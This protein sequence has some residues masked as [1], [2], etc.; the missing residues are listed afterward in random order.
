MNHKQA[1]RL[2]V[3]L[4]EQEA[5]RHAVNANMYDLMH[6]D[7]PATR[8]ASKRRADCRA[9]IDVLQQPEQLVMELEAA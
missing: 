6:L 2:A 8:N 5:K 9:A 1:I 7:T 3:E 4:L